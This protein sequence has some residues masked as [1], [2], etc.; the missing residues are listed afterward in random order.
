MAT[1]VHS[2]PDGGVRVR[3]SREEL[4]F[5]QSLP[6]QLEPVLNGS[7]DVAGARRRL[8][9]P[10]Y[11]DP[12]D[13][14]EYRE[15]M[16]ADLAEERLAALRAFAETLE[17]ARRHAAAWQL[18]LDGDQA[19]A[20]LS[21]TNDARLVLA[22]VVGITSE[23]RWERAAVPGDPVATA[24]IYLGALQEELLAALGAGGTDEA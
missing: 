17:A 20:W 9:P 13:D 11:D 5:L 8:F 12:D 19:E 3:L 7:D 18:D 21:A 4:E 6:D 10:A 23:D 14:A 22:H 16:G 24:L 15:M 1:R 2:S